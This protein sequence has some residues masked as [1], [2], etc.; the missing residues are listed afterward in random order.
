MGKCYCG[1]K[2]HNKKQA[3]D[4]QSGL[5]PKLASCMGALQGRE[6]LLECGQL[7]PGFNMATHNKGLAEVSR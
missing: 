6:E 3:A 2:L 4:C 7:L 5:Q 1:V